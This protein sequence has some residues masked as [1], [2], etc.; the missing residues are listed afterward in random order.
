MK[1][2]DLRVNVRL[3]LFCV[4]VGLRGLF[5][6]FWEAVKK[7][8]PLDLGLRGERAPDRFVFPDDVAYA[9]PVT[10]LRICGRVWEE[11]GAFREAFSDESLEIIPTLSIPNACLLAF[12]CRD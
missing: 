8:P 6:P 9:S 7:P 11:L 4:C 3:D 1:Y 10:F 2:Y 12:S 5:P